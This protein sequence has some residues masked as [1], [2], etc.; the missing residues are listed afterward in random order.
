MLETGGPLAGR[1]RE[2]SALTAALMARRGAVIT[3]P[4]GAGKTTLAAV[5]LQLAGDRE[6]PVART[7]ATHPSQRLP[8]GALAP[9]LPTRALTA[10]PWPARTSF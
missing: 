8:F 5:C 9:I 6:M 3:G 10:S 4:A 2:L 1:G 7:R